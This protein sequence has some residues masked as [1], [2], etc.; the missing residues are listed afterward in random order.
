MLVGL[1][2]CYFMDDISTGLDSSTTFDIVKSLRNIT[3]VLDLT[4]AISL[5]QPLQET[6][7][8]FD[9]VILLCEGKIAYQG[10]RENIL[11]FF[12]S[13]G[14]SCPKRKNPV[15]FLQEVFML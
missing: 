11:P 10:P 12:N 8:L 13:M 15:D 14:F 5:L 6:Y 7:E 4:T 2:R 1:S 9:D 3:R